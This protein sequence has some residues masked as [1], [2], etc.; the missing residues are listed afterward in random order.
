MIPILGRYG[1]FFLTSY[2]VVLGIGTL[3]ALAVTAFYARRLKLPGWIDGVLLAAGVAV[4]AGRLAF[5]LLNQD[6]FGENAGQAWA[7]WQGGLNAQAALIGGLLTYAGW[8]HVTHRPRGDYLD[9]IAPGLAI[10]F[11]AGWAACWFEGCAYGRETVPG[12][13]SAA[14]PDDFG[15][16]AMRYQTQTLGFILSAIIAGLASWQLSRRPRSSTQSGFLFWLTLLALTTVHAL[17]TLFRGDPA[18]VWLGL[19]ADLLVDLLVAAS[20]LLAALSRTRLANP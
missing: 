1:P 2:F 15:V 14:L 4:L 9:L 20:G 18:P 10:V 17:I 16:V 7:I 11:A 12:L 19:R 5:V 13:L 3:A 8:L 6:Y